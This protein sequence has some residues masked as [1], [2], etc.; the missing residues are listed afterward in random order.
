MKMFYVLF[1][2]SVILIIGCASQGKFV[3]ADDPFE[4]LS[5]MS[6]K[7][8][9]KG[10]IASVG[11]A[12]G[13]RE[14]TAEENAIATA[15]V[16][17]S[18]SYGTKVSS[19]TKKFLEEVGSDNPEINAQFSI[20]TKQVSQNIIKMSYVKE[21]RFFKNTKTHQVEC[22]ILMVVDPSTFNTELTNEMKNQDILYQRFVSSKAFDE[23]KQEETNWEK[24]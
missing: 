10:G 24:D 11:R 17:L 19:L 18:E 20:V 23:L 7:I 16:R 5:K 12:Y 9:K 8:I 15:R 1:S 4:D 2:V 3:A 6:N 13:M 22:G 14:D 21:R